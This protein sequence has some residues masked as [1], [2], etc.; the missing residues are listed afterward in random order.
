M[1][2]KRLLG[3]WKST[4]GAG[5]DPLTI[6]FR[7]DG[8]MTYTI[9]GPHSDQKIFLRYTAENGVIVSDQPSEPREEQTAYRF[10]LGGQLVLIY[11]AEESTFDPEL[12]STREVVQEIGAGPG[13]ST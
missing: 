1:S 3:R 2:D 4:K 8:S 12:V 11:D 10:T 6:E 13:N 9:H 5:G 7:R